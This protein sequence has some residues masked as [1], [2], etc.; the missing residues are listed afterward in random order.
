MLKVSSL[1]NVIYK[2]INKH[3]EIV[4]CCLKIVRWQTEAVATRN[5]SV[6]HGSPLRHKQ[7]FAKNYELCNPVKDSLW[8]F[9]HKRTSPD[10]ML[11]MM[12]FEINWQSPITHVKLAASPKPDHLHVMLV[13]VCGYEQNPSRGVWGVTH[14]R[15]PDVRTDVYTDGRMDVRRRANLNAWG[16]NNDMFNYVLQLCT[17]YTVCQL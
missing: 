16:H 1:Y 11:I 13:T 9:S 3:T 8:I 6:G 12:N 2:Y 7:L 10:G 15:F 17:Y 4:R 14:T 5:V